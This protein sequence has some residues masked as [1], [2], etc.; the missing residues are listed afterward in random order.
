MEGF[1]LD[2]EYSEEHEECA[3]LTS[4]NDTQDPSAFLHRNL[5]S[6]DAEHVVGIQKMP[7]VPGTC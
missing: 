7:C 1:Y 4:E 3:L 6:V 5:S 2:S